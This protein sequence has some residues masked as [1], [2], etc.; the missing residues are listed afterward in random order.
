[1]FCDCTLVCLNKRVSSHLFLITTAWESIFTFT[2]TRA[3]CDVLCAG[4]EIGSF[5]VAQ[6]E[7]TGELSERELEEGASGHN[8]DR[9]VVCFLCWSCSARAW[10]WLA[11]PE[12]KGHWANPVWHTHCDSYNQ[13]QQSHRHFIRQAQSICQGC[14]AL[15]WKAILFSGLVLIGSDV[16]HFQVMSK[17]CK[18]TQKKLCLISRAGGSAPEMPFSLPPQHLVGLGW[19]RCW[20][21]GQGYKH[22]NIWH[23]WLHERGGSYAEDDEGIHEGLLDLSADVK[24]LNPQSTVRLFF[25]ISCRYQICRHVW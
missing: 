23:I 5:S 21:R 24:C 22:T 9:C 6:N 7:S 18:K 3:F 8:V 16:L 12:G 10:C 19:E 25:S 11:E 14:A 15:G 13:L 17:M 1:M 2:W 20:P 4:F